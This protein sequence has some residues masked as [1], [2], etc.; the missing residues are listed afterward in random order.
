ML[1]NK[2]RSACASRELYCL[3]KTCG[4]FYFLN[5]EMRFKVVNSNFLQS[6]WVRI[7]RLEFV[8]INVIN[9]TCKSFSHIFTVN[10][11]YV[12]YKHSTIYS[13]THTTNAI[14]NEYFTPT[15]HTGNAFHNLSTTSWGLTRTIFLPSPLTSRQFP[16]YCMMLVLSM[17]CV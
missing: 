9:Y 6:I 8:I 12:E 11:A 3:R 10:N 16:Q 1:L 17:V 7:E 4:Y 5:E 14:H 13:I 15:I 2:V